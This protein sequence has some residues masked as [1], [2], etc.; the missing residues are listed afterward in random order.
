MG[1]TI[2]ANK[3][4]EKAT[5]AAAIFGQLSQ[6]HTDRIVRAAY[7]AAFDNRVK[8]AKL[9]YEETGKGKWEDKVIKNAVATQFVYDDIKDLKTVGIISEDEENGIVEIA[10][11]IGPIF[12]LIPVTNPT[13][14]VMF[15]ILIALKTRNPIIIGP[16][17]N[18]IKC[19]T[20]AARI[21]YEAALKEDAPEDCV[22]W[23]SE[24]SMDITHELMG[25]K[26]LSLVLATGGAGLV[27]AAYSSGTPAIGVGPGNVPVFVEKSAD[28]RFAVEQIIISK[29][30]DNGTVCASEQAIVAE[31][32]IADK[33]VEEFK[34]QKCYF[35][36]RE[37][38]KALEKV[39]YDPK[40]ELMN[41]EIVGKPAPVIAKMAGIDVP[42]DTKLL[43]VRLDEV[44]K[45]C[46]LS[47]EILAPILA[48]YKVGGFDDAINQCIDLNFYGGTGHTVSMYSNDEDKIKKFASV[49]NAGRI[50]L[51]TPSSQ[52]AVGGIYNTLNPSFTLGCGS[53]GKNITTDNITAKHL[54]NIQR[55]ARRRVNRR[56]E[57]FDQNLYFDES[58]DA[59]AIEKKFDMN[60]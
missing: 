20:E 37:E 52:G 16:H 18:A 44:G 17:P 30:F 7:E 31:R 47:G 32:A 21:C 50:L 41:A 36:S 15:K 58:L 33:V 14:T 54:L 4:M 13:S 5:S 3:I 60:D 10:Q 55:I 25:H 34:Q 2:D 28:A 38:G 24:V 26:D 40:R 29:T 42:D 57:H 59:N 46:P 43:L 1:N 51:N 53:G 45:E 56:L 12:A 22:Q 35:L 6:E 27:H 23:L 39:A 49:M 48:F 19:S 9:A 8:L 11:P